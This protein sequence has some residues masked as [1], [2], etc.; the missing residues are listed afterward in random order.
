MAKKLIVNRK[1]FTRLAE[2]EVT[3]KMV[4][5]VQGN[6]VADAVSAINNPDTQRQLNAAQS[7]AGDVTISLQ[8]DGYQDNGPTQ[9]V[10]KQS[11][12]SYDTAL[13]SQ[14][15]PDLFA[16]NPSAEV[17]DVVDEGTRFTKK[18]LEEARLANIKKNGRVCTKKT[19]FEE[20]YGWDDFCVTDELIQELK[21]TGD[22]FFIARC[23]DDSR[24]SKCPYKRLCANSSE[25]QEAIFKEIRIAGVLAVTHEM[26]G[27]IAN[28][29]V[30]SQQ[31]DEA[32]RVVKVSSLPDT[33]DFYVIPECDY[34][35]DYEEEEY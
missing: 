14:L 7:A 3:P 17:N 30:M 22:F 19:L 29:P 33:A 23:P 21:R 31:F 12:E 5:P 4:V 24:N 15:N 18:Q 27:F 32:P 35:E 6:T 2:A 11:G 25:V 1:Q 20:T 9:A 10:N 28:D 13:S 26:D 8:G 16:K 34:D